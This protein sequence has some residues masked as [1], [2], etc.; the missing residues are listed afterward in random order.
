M[1]AA[2]KG[3]SLIEAKTYRYYGHFQGDMVTY[4]TDEEL[5]PVSSSGTRSSR[6]RN[7]AIQHG[8][9]TAEE[10]DAID[11]RTREH[12]DTGLEGRQGRALAGRKRAA[13]R[14]LRFLLIAYR[15][16][17]SLRDGYRC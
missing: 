1:P 16:R 14:R 6:S 11:T 5:E 3:P 4:R 17:G 7:Y 8:M 2:A 13:D 10:L 12:L 15:E 9:A